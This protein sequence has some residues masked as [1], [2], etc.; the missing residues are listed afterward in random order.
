MAVKA[1]LLDAGGTLWEPGRQIGGR[2]GVWFQTLTQ[3]GFNVS[4]AS[5]SMAYDIVWI[6]FAHRWNRMETWGLPNPSEVVDRF[7]EEFNIALVTHLDM[8][9]DRHILKSR[10]E[11]NSLRD[12]LYPDTELAIARLR[13][14]GYKLA[15]VSNGSHQRD[16]AH[17]LGIA[18]CFYAVVSSTEI[19]YRKPMPEVFHAALEKLG[20]SAEEAIM[21]GDSYEAD[22]LCARAAG[23]EALHLIRDPETVSLMNDP[24]TIADLWGVV[25][26]LESVAVC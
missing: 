16:Y 6:S 21:I 15:I 20:V 22:V 11:S 17:R 3:L 2:K 23:I 14:L 5:V 1:I 10:L 18:R 13:A 24:E 19:G 4:Q 7:W 8:I 25:R 26:H 9:A 12:A